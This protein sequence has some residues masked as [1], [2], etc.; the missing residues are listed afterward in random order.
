[1][2]KDGPP[3]L[4][5]QCS[6]ANHNPGQPDDRSVSELSSRPDVDRS[7]IDGPP[8]LNIHQS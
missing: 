6:G 1:M 8:R 5:T 3:R 4:N 7:G 2:G